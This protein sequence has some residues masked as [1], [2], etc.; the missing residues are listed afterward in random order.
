M[1]IY[2]PVYKNKTVDIGRNV[3]NFDDDCIADVTGIPVRSIKKFIGRNSGLTAPTREALKE[4]RKPKKEAKVIQEP[5]PVKEEPKVEEKPVEE[6]KVEEPKEEPK[7]E[8]KSAEKPKA[9]KAASKKKT[10][11]K[12]AP[13]KTK[14]E[15]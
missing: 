12:R 4:L 3:L 6:V 7:A 5:V 1:F 11:T 15:E 14:K 13:K 8:E 10:T 2:C 9:K